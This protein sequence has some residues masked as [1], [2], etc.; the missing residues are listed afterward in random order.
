[1]KKYII[2]SDMGFCGT[3]QEHDEIYLPDDQDPETSDEIQAALASAYEAAIQD[4]SAY[5]EEDTD[6]EDEDE[7]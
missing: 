5:Y 2:K 6:Y 4:V 7:D 3:D 1:M